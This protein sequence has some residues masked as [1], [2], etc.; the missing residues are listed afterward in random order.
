M[1]TFLPALCPRHVTA[2]QTRSIHTTNELLLTGTST[3]EY[4]F[5]SASSM[6]L[7]QER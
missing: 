1:H 6:D 2:K 4:L 3:F 5:Q 7:H